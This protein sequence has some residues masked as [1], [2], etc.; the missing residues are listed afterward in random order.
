MPKSVPV[1][2][3]GDFSHF[4]NESGFYAERLSEH[5][6]RHHITTHPHKHDFYLVV[7]FTKGRGTH[8]IDF[9]SYPVA[10]GSLF[11]LNP[12]QTHIWHVSKDTEGYI[13]F[14]TREFYDSAFSRRQLHDYPFFSSVHHSPLLGSKINKQKLISFFSGLLEEY[15]AQRPDKDEKLPAL[16]HLLYLEL[17]RLYQDSGTSTNENYRIRFREFENLL[18]SNFKKL[19]LPREYSEKMNITERHLNRITRFCVN[20]SPSALILERVILEA[21]RILTHNNPSIASV[22]DHLGYSD[23][24]YFS[25]LFK[26][27]TGQSPKGFMTGYQF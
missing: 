18:D 13:F 11:L 16:V 15:K 2:R 19:K 10:P 1:V 7:L 22:A 26:K 27:Q 25:R 24:S 14:H 5:I 3:I 6:R 21:R 17:A 12:G 20:K 4:G 9:N 8:E 23:Q